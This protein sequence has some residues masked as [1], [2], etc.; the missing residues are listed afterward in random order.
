MSA[1]A[2]EPLNKSQK[3]LRVCADCFNDEA[4]KRFVQD[5]KCDFWGA[6]GVSSAL[7][8]E[9]QRF[10][11][12]GL[13]SVWSPDPDQWAVAS[14]SADGPLYSIEDVLEWAGSTIKSE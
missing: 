4:I 6:A 12:E 11:H 3:D 1:F 8:D 7:W 10:I 5:S 9:R 13:E 2:T 14:D